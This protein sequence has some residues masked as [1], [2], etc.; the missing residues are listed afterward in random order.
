[1]T[2]VCIAALAL[3]SALA[4]T[5]CQPV[6]DNA[7]GGQSGKA[8]TR[9]A[10][11]TAGI[12]DRVKDGKFTFVVT[13][14]AAG[15]RRIGDQYLGK[16]AQG[17]FILV[18]VTVTNHGDEAQSFMGDAQKLLA[19]GKEYSADSEAGIYLKSSQSLYEEINP[20]NRVRGIVVFDV[21]KPVVPSVIRLHDSPFSGGVRVDVKE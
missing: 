20:G 2:L 7:A 4:L 11:K 6:A 5:G 19:G 9:P 17:K 14:V 8:T 1:M 15:P 21:P 13:K 10:K 12:G 18:H 16:T 3:V